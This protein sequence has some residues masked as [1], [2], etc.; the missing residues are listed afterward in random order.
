M[1]FCL[2]FAPHT[3]IVLDPFMGSGT[4]GVAAVRSERRFIGIE[5][6]PDYFQIALERLEAATGTFSP[7]NFGGLFAETETQ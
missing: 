7:R 6:D 5:R 1:G 4:T 3:K 2:S